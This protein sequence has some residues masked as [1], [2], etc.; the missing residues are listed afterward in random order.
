MQHPP[1]RDLALL[2]LAVAAVSTAAPLVLTL[3][4]DGDPVGHGDTLEYALRFGNRSA[5]PQLTTTLA[6]TL[7]PG[8][9][10]LD[11]GGATVAGGTATWTLSAPGMPNVEVTG[12]TIV[13]GER[14][15]YAASHGLSAWLLILAD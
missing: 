6:L 5:T 12:L 3:D 9:T 7:P 14:R 4:E 1:P 10:V 11:A 15:L 2:G 8:T 13:P